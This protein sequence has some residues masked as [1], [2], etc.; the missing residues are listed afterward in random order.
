MP[1]SLER[2][3]YIHVLHMRSRDRDGV[4][5]CDF[6]D[7][8]SAKEHV[9]TPY[10]LLQWCKRKRARCYFFQALGEHRQK[11]ASSLCR[12]SKSEH[13]KAMAK[14]T[15]LCIR[16]SPSQHTSTS[17]RLHLAFRAHTY[18]VSSSVPI[19]HARPHPSLSTHQLLYDHFHSNRKHLPVLELSLRGMHIRKYSVAQPTNYCTWFYFS[20][21]LRHFSQ[22]FPNAFCLH[23][24]WYA[25]QE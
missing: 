1:K 11:I 13:W 6:F 2:N 9:T 24:W 16:G 3:C 7:G 10:W 23:Q 8:V 12:G 18:K 15:R 17:A 5:S 25:P 19:V 21:T 20:V 4:S 22:C 14:R